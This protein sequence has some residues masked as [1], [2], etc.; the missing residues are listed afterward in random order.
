MVTCSHGGSVFVAVILTY[1]RFLLV[2]FQVAWDANRK[3]LARILKATICESCSQLFSTLQFTPHATSLSN[4]EWPGSHVEDV[5]IQP[6]K[7]HHC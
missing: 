2:D 4:R 3:D 6:C 5:D 1:T 7:A